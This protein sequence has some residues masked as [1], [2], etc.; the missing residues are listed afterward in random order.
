MNKF[1]SFTFLNEIRLSKQDKYNY[2]SGYSKFILYPG[3]IVPKKRLI[4]TIDFLW[5]NEWFEYGGSMVIAHT[6]DDEDYSLE[7]VLRNKNFKNE[8][9]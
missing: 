2:K 3:R 4:E 5:L 9:G 7:K 8:P 1:P 6:N